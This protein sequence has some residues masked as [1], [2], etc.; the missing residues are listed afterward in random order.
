LAT[1]LKLLCH[2]S[3]LAVRT[4]SFPANEPLDVQGREKLSAISHRWR[5]ADHYLASPAL[6]SMQTAEALRLSVTAAPALRDCDYGRW[7]GRCFEEVHAREPDAVAEWLQNPAAAPHGG[8][9]ILALM[10]RVN[11]WLE[12]RKDIRGLTVAITHASVVRAVIV[13]AIKAG[14]Q[15]FWHIDVAPLTLARLSCNSGRWALVSIGL[16]NSNSI[17]A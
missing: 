6:P 16:L 15:S 1:Q 2:A 7:S 9:S 12:E 10:E 3:T 14:P 5:G 17:L 8:E 11:V 4:T 13:L